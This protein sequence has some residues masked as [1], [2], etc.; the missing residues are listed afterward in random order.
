[1]KKLILILCLIPT[2][3]VFADTGQ[4]AVT[5]IAATTAGTVPAGARCLIFSAPSGV[6]GTIA[7][8]PYVALERRTLPAQAGDTLGPVP[9]TVSGGTLYITVL[10]R[11]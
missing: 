3:L 4:E 9:Y 6:T 8:A 10:Q 11:R 5:T 7:T 2:L 1:M